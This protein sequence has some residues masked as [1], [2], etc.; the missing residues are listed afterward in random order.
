M[1]AGELVPRLQNGTD[2]AQKTP[3]CFV[4]GP[5]GWF[6]FPDGKNCDIP[7]QAGALQTRLRSTDRTGS[8]EPNWSI[9]DQIGA[10]RTRLERYGPDW[11]VTDQTGALWTRL[12]RYVQ[13]GASLAWELRSRSD[14]NIAD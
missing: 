1:T 5:W 7:V 13:T 9:T 2:N 6:Y 10:L 11:S 3:V 12:G 8:Y 14:W 4:S